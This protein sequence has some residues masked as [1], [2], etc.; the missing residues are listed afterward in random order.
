MYWDAVP[1]WEFSTMTGDIYIYGY[2]GTDQRNAEVSF[3]NVNAQLKQNAAA[4]ELTVHIISGGGDVFEGEA[5]YNALRNS[6]KKVTTHIEGTCASIAT[7]IAAAGDHVVMNRTARFM[8]HNPKISGLTQA[9]DAN[10]LRQVAKQLDQ[11][12]TLLIGVYD[13]RT[14]LGTE[15]L[16]ELYDKESWF[17]ADE[18]HASGFVDEVVDAIRAVAKVDLN[19]MTMQKNENW[20]AGLYRWFI[21]LPK[22]KSMFTETLQDGKVIMVM[23]EDEDWTGKQVVYEDGTPLPAGDHVLQ[24]GKTIT[25]DES[26]VI[27]AVKE[28][29]APEQEA[30]KENTEEMEN[31]KIK[32][33]ETQLAEMKAAKDRA[34]NELVESRKASAQAANETAKVQNKLTS[35]EAEFLKFKEEMSKTVGDNTPPPAGPAFKNT[36][37][38]KKFDPMGD[39]ALKYYKNRNLA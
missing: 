2:I 20:Y 34:E 21:K 10:Q 1:F 19:R 28:A 4:D 22:I 31:Q 36:D 16:W 30:P 39:E 37:G 15:K 25:V 26:S 29:A 5:I 23:S 35:F 33:L 8:I 6:G 17:T 7:L 38:E 9:A 32:E 14:T 12:K 13:R 27:T 24:T 11:V 3:E 18:A